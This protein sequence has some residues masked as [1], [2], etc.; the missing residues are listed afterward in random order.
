MVIS[1]LAEVRKIPWDIACLK[2]RDQQKERIRGEV[3]YEITNSIEPQILWQIRNQIWSEI[4]DKM[5]R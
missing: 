5:K 3:R 4:E 2:L 1:K